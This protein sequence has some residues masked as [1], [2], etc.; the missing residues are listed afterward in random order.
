MSTLGFQN[1]RTSQPLALLQLV[2]SSSAPTPVTSSQHRSMWPIAQ[3]GQENT[4]SPWGR[5]QKRLGSTRD[6]H[7]DS[8]PCF[9]PVISQNAPNCFVFAEWSF[10]LPVHFQA[11]QSSVAG[12]VPF[13]TYPA[14]A[15]FALLFYAPGP[16]P[17]FCSSH[18]CRA[19]GGCWPGPQF[20]LVWVSAQAA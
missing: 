5:W 7:E 10:A 14:G 8:L 12:V 20:L 2:F 15:S 17:L 19:S 13:R 11:M 3:G 18:A 1:P 9:L 4:R 6:Q 16:R